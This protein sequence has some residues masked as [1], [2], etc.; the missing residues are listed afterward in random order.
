MKAIG[1]AIW[2]RSHQTS[3]RLSSHTRRRKKPICRLDCALVVQFRDVRGHLY[4]PKNLY[5]EATFQPGTV[6]SV[7]DAFDQASCLA[8][9]TLRTLRQCSVGDSDMQLASRWQDP[10]RLGVG[11]GSSE[12][13]ADILSQCYSLEHLHVHVVGWDKLGLDRGSVVINSASSSHN[14]TQGI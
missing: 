9:I 5:F 7:I 10:K 1:S 14:L 11:F 4:L 12:E 3:L 6:P 8:S 2:H 13:L